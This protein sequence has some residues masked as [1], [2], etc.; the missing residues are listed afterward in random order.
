M[1]NSKKL[2]LIQSIVWASAGMLASLLFVFLGGPIFR[3]L[4]RNLG[5]V[6]YFLFSL[7]FTIPLFIFGIVPAGFFAL[8]IWTVVGSYCFFESK[9]HSGF[10]PGFVAVA[11]GVSIATLGPL[12]FFKYQEIDYVKEYSKSVL[13]VVQNWKSKSSSKLTESEIKTIAETSLHVIPGALGVILTAILSIAVMFA[14]RLGTALGARM[15]KVA[16][17]VRPM[18]IRVPDLFVWITMF[19]F[20]LCF[21][22]LSKAEGLVT[23]QLFGLNIFMFM[24]GFYFFQGIAVMETGFRA[25]RVNSFFRL[26]TYLLIAGNLF[27]IV[28]IIGFADF[29]IDFRSR[30]RSKLISTQKENGEWL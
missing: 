13:T 18:E 28:C 29:W 2:T 25:F 26:M 9:G 17:A 1:R 12:A 4:Y 14:E 20:L 5:P 24:M 8:S 21:V 30:W 11:L 7:L 16:S 15:E 27:F 19:S 10:W 23:A 6:R 22:K 3:V